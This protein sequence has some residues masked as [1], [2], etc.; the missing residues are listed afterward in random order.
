M[1]AGRTEF[2]M[3]LF[4]R[5]YGRNDHRQRL[6]AWPRSRSL[7]LD[8]TGDRRRPRLCHRGPQEPR[9][10]PERRHQAT[11][12]SPISRGVALA[13]RH[14][15]SSR[16]RRS[17]NE[18]RNQ[19]EHPLV[20][21]PPED[22]STFP[23]A[24]SRRW[25]CSK[26]LFA[27][28]EVLILDEPTRGIDVGAKYE[29]YT[30]HQPA[31]RRRQRRHRHLV[32]NAGAA[33]HLRP[34]LRDERGRASSTRWRPS[35]ASQE[36]IMRVDHAKSERRSMQLKTAAGERTRAT[37]RH[38]ARAPR[39]RLLARQSARLRPAALAAPD[40]GCS[41]S[42]S[43]AACCW[44]PLNIT[45]LVL[46]N[47]YIVI[48]ALGMLLVI[49]GGHIDLSV[50]SIVGFV[51]AI[52]A[53]MMVRLSRALECRSVIICARC[54]AAL[55]GAAQGYLVAYPKIPSFI[56]TLAGM[57]IFRGLTWHILLGQFVGPFPNDFPEL[58]AP[59]SFP[60]CLRGAAAATLSATLVFADRG[61]RCWRCRR[62]SMSASSARALARERTAI[63]AEPFALLRRQERHLFALL[64][65]GFQLSARVLSRPAQRAG[66]HG[67]ADRC[68]IASSPRARPSA[69]ASM[70]SAATGKAAQLSGIKT[71]RL[72]FLTFVNMGVLAGARRPDRSPRG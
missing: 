21:R 59:A 69:G 62:W 49:V 38:A 15:R 58:S 6:A 25:C 28:P 34:H 11:S 44:S 26:W 14:R 5:A 16:S 45:N 29:I 57:L 37:D 46:Q 68:S 52:A 3:S 35:E 55:I 64:I 47:S 70:R 56:V 17:P 23:A 51:G 36:K 41:S 39:T 33:R 50:G 48:M 20:E 19:H 12:R 67:R 31:R 2:A 65:I 54:S 27:D 22:R 30:H 40:H 71:E 66:H 7:E 9:P 42:S 32:G 10:D 1:G 24:T 8:Q 63:E 53:I 13:R 43:P 60:D 72:T 18:Y 61:R 4:G